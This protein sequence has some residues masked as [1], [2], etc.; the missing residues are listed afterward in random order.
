MVGYLD[1]SKLGEIL[2]IF[3]VKLE[4]ANGINYVIKVGHFIG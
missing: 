3:L 4:L 2:T 1:Y